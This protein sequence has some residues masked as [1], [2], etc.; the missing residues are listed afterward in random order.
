MGSRLPLS[1]LVSHHHQQPS[2]LSGYADPD[3]AL[4]KS[5]SHHKRF[6]FPAYEKKLKEEEKMYLLNLLF[7][8]CCKCCVG[9]G[10]ESFV[11]DLAKYP[12][13]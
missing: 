10:S 2:Y 9:S 3:P 11:V 4:H 5:V 13:Y 7:L 6:V 12:R 1:T 8:S